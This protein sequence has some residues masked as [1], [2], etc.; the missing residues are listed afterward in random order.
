MVRWSIASPF[1][2]PAFNLP[3]IVGLGLSVVAAVWLLA[4]PFPANLIIVPALAV[5]VAYL[6]VPALAPIALVASVPVQLAGAVS[7]GGIQLT[8]TKVALAAAVVAFLL[9]LLTRHD[10]IRGSVII[11]PYLAYLVA[12]VISLYAAVDVREGVAE[13]YRWIVP[14][15][16]FVL[17]LYGVRTRRAVLAIPVVLSACV[18]AESAGGSVQSLL[19]L[20]PASFAVQAGLSRAYGTFGKPNTY[21]GYLEMTGPLLLAFCIWGIGRVVA[22][23]R[24]YRAQRTAGMVASR[25]ARMKL[26]RWVL[27]TL[28]VGAAALSSLVGIALSFSRGA[29]LGIAAGLVVMLMVTARRVPFLRIGLLVI[30]A[31]V[32]VGGGMRYAPAALKDRYQQL[33]NQVH[34]FDSRDVT[35]TP[36]NFAAVERMEHWQTGVG[37]FKSSPLV[38]IGIGNFTKRYP[39][40]Y[41]H[42]GF[43]I[44]EGHAHNYYIH[45]LAETGLIGLATYLTMMGT[46]LVVCFRAARRA[47]DGLGRV[48]G[49]GALGVTVAVMVHNVVENLHVLNL[50]IQLLAVWALAVIAL[51][52][53]PSMTAIE[54]AGTSCAHEPWER[55]VG[56]L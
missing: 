18:L 11:I 37:M 55:T 8:A 4:L 10:S 26:L 46:G 43:P 44:S 30:V 17:V 49:V 52:Y 47:P 3:A 2:A 36:Q 29:W 21:A 34:V 54:S 19:A 9:Q 27:F 1:N 41:V 35:V 51:R 15:F 39:D 24:G 40:F 53:L 16:A 48:I 32:L 50:N 7:I 33:V 31:L 38:G 13:I 45:A 6:L 20:G 42:S 5:G 14:L 56:T 23:F 12:M 25:E 28:W 22:S